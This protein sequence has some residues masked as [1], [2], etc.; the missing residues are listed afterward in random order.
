VIVGSQRELDVVVRYGGEEILV[1]LPNTRIVD[2]VEL[3]KRLRQNIQEKIMVGPD[4]EKERPQGMDAQVPLAPWMEKERPAIS[5]TVSIG[6][7]GYLFSGDVDTANKL[8]ARADQALY[9][10]KEQGRNRVVASNG[11]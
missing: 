11:C 3:A 2:A 5:V 10:A 7:A 1:I 6:V 4:P 8:V 9:Q